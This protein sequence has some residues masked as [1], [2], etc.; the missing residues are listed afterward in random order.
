M[1]GRHLPADREARSRA[2]EPGLHRLGCRAVPL[3]LQQ[4]QPQGCIAQGAGYIQVIAHLRARA[5]DHPVRC[6]T[7]QG[8]RQHQA[9]RRTHIPPN[10]RRATGL[11]RPD[12]PVEEC[13]K[14]FDLTLLRHP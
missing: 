3:F 4:A 6:L 13:V 5:R 10:Q 7:K 11:R 9:R 12:K 14:V 2:E 1:A 8:H